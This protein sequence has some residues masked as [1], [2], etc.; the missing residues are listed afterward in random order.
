MFTRLLLNVQIFRVKCRV[1]I[2]IPN[3]IRGKGKNLDDFAF[4]FKEK[5]PSK[6]DVNE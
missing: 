5:K 4:P 1:I 2:I 6:R 3:I